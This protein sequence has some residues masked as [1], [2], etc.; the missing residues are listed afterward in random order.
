M[1]VWD[2]P[3]RLW[4]VARKIEDLLEL[5]RKTREALEKLD[6]R[7]RAVEDRMTHLEAG[8]EQ[9]ITEAKAA[10]GVA[11]TGLAGSVI[12]EVVTRITRIEMRQDEIQRRL[13]PPA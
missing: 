3:A 5:Q 6:A 1:A 11:A 10:A 13:P 12:S 4:T 8:Q 7:L 2:V 9:L